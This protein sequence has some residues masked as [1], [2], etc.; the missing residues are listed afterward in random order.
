ML[1]AAWGE[2]RR[3]LSYKTAACGGAVVA[4]NPAYSSRTCRVCGHESADNRKTQAVF[5]C[6]ACGHTEHADVHAAKV[7]LARGIAAWQESGAQ[8]AHH[9]P[10]N[11]TAA[12]HAASAHGEA[13]RPGLRASARRAAS[14]KWEP[15]EEAARA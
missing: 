10:A 12:G 1:D 9:K 3:Q 7:I 4:V 13:V 11:Q 5:A 2:F 14:A 6:V 15:A 8:P